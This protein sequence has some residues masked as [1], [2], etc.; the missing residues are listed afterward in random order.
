[1]RQKENFTTCGKCKNT[2]KYQKEIFRITQ[3]QLEIKFEIKSLLFTRQ[4]CKNK[5]TKKNH[6][7]YDTFYGNKINVGLGF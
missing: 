4:N 3:K 7:L 6:N 1:M 5:S 2:Q